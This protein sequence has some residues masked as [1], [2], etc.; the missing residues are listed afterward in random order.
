MQPNPTREAIAQAIFKI[1]DPSGEWGR[2]VHDAPTVADRY[3]KCA[4]LALSRTFTDE[5][6]ERAAKLL[7]AHHANVYAQCSA[8]YFDG[9]APNMVRLV[10]AAL[11]NEPPRL[12]DAL[13]SLPSAV[14]EETV[15]PREN[16][17]PWIL[18]GSLGVHPET[19]AMVRQFSTALLVK[20]RHAEE[21]YG[22]SDGW[23]TED[24]EDECRRQLLAHVEKGDPLDVAAYAAFCWARRWSTAPVGDGALASTSGTD[25]LAR[26]EPKPSD[27][28]PSTPDDFDVV[29]AGLVSDFGGTTLD[30]AYAALSR[31]QARV[32][33]T[34]ADAAR[35]RYLLEHHSYSYSMEVV[36]PSPAEKGIEWHWQQSKPGEQLLS[37]EDLLDADIARAALETKADD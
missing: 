14:G 24:W 33:K 36:E 13:N 7:I 28:T 5:E 16:P 21:K 1:L 37:F 29:R 34:E 8:F 26:D 11:S 6:V 31:L 19:L 32:V 20:L 9:E 12:V 2:T 35:F 18:P 25:D 27:S 23:L 4:D 22:Y 3:R 15:K 17:E 10:I 30:R